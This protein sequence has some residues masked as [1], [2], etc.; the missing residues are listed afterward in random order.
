M[1]YA[2][3]ALVLLCLAAHRGRWLSAHDIAQHIQQA[4]AATS[5]ACAALARTQQID[6]ASRDG[7]PVFGRGCEGV[8]P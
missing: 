5:E 7:A 1:S 8:K 2:L 6:C 4:G 3:Q